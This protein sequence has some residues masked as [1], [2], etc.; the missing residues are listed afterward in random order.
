M[1]NKEY[2]DKYPALK[3]FIDSVPKRFEKGTTTCDGEDCLTQLTPTTFNVFVTPKCDKVLMLCM[4]C[5][6]KYRIQYNISFQN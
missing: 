4:R 5:L 6:H 1:T 2:Y 3:E